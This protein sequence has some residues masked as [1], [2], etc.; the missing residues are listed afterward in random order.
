MQDIANGA[1]QIKVSVYNFCMDEV[2]NRVIF[3]ETIVASFVVPGEG[4]PEIK[5]MVGSEHKSIIYVTGNPTSMA[6]F[7]YDIFATDNE[8]QHC[9]TIV[10]YLSCLYT[11]MLLQQT[12]F[13]A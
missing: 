5:G 11:S 4:D 2:T 3:G 1:E 6:N 13:W 10:G 8:R 12:I 9:I 7:N